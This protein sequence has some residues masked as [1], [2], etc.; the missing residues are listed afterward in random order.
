M[1]L[2]NFDFKAD[3]LQLQAFIR[4]HHEPGLSARRC[5]QL[6][7][8]FDRPTDI[9]KS[10]LTKLCTILPIKLATQLLAPLQ[11]QVLN[12][13]QTTLNWGAQPNCHLLTWAD[14]NYPSPL[15]HMYDP[16]ILL[17]VKGNLKCLGMPSIAIVGTRD[18]SSYGFGVAT[19]L[20]YN[21]AQAGWC[22][23]SGLARG[24]DAAAHQGALATKQKHSTLAVMGH[25]LDTVY[26]PQHVDLAHLIV[27]QQGALLSELG[28]DKPPRP[29]QFP[30]RN[31]LVAGL[32]R[33]VIV[34]EANE[35]SGSL[36]T[37]RL[38]NELGRD[39]FAVPGPITSPA[40]QGVHALIKQG[41][42]LIENA[43]DV[44]EELGYPT[45][46]RPNLIL[47]NPMQC[48]LTPLQSQ[49]LQLIGHAPTNVTQLLSNLNISAQ[50]L[51]I[52]LTRLELAG[53]I[54]REEHGVV[55]AIRGVK[56]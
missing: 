10:S 32:V 34:V 55:C 37:A 24:I 46:L 28:P 36:I 27:S 19:Q 35:R 30:R 51:H 41:A 9:F 50:S 20:A 21:F 17:Y 7:A 1:T 8:A 45:P 48:K 12:D 49:I 18:A 52:E 42:C 53:L 54:D 15:K 5:A 14:S 26:P 33:G 38:A 31:R 23:I 4:L 44:F 13:L 22:V 40:S 47:P 2:T 6:M 39:I 3:D 29:H 16:P 25:G 43:D 11:T 56:Y